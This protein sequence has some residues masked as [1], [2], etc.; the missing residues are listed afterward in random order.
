M[1]RAFVGLSGPLF[2][3]Y[4]NP[5]REGTPEVSDIPNPVLE[6]VTGLLLCYDE[7]WF[8]SREVCP[9]DLHNV[10]YVK[11]LTD[12]EV[13]LSRALVAHEQYSDLYWNGFF[14]DEL[15][16]SDPKFRGDSSSVFGTTVDRVRAAVKF[17]FIADNH[18]RGIE[19]FDQGNAAEDNLIADLG[20]AASLDMG[21]EVVMNSF[22]ASFPVDDVAQAAKDGTFEQWRV[23]TAEEVVALKTIDFLGPRGAYHPSLDDL[24]AHPRVSE[25]R[26]FL[27]SASVPT[28][29]IASL[30]K[31]VERAAEKNARDALER[32]LA[33]NGKLFTI[34]SAALGGGGNL[35]HPGLGNFLSG[36]LT[37]VQWLRER[38]RRKDTAWS[39]FV[40]D[41]RR[42]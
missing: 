41:A 24:R 5:M 21:L 22:T 26:E 28:T 34:G 25:F 38:K 23:E 39:L 30:V 16:A 42:R 17:D 9:I 29:G 4:G 19:G 15:P 36:T 6:N 40:I 12:D 1:K 2:Y 37:G 27:A 7:I 3:D 31:E 10:E 13:L 32:D 35:F 11:F 18:S 14:D 8:L 20:I 33:G